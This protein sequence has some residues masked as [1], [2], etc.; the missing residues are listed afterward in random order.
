MTVFDQNEPRPSKP[1]AIRPQ[2]IN[3]KVDKKSLGKLIA[4]S[5]ITHGTARTA[6]LADR[7]KD[8]G[9]RYATK[10]GVSISVEDLEVPKEK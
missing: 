6:T 1:G 2:F 3:R 10:A 7:L 9:F 4:W 8:L 5:F